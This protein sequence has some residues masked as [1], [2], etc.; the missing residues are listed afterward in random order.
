MEQCKRGPICRA[1]TAV[2]ILVSLMSLLASAFGASGPVRAGPSAAP[3]TV[4]VTPGTVT[5]GGQVSITGN[6]FAPGE[7]VNLQLTANPQ[8][9]GSL[10]LGTVTADTA[11]NFA[12]TNLTI[13]VSQPAGS[14]LVVAIGLFSG[15]Q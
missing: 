12:L 15:P 1:I 2:I 7:T 8:Q 5:A 3:A 9:T 11:G 6:G 14:Y 13:L 10:A 4:S